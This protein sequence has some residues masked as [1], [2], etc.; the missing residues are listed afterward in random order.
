MR[1]TISTLVAVA[2]AL[3]LIAA[4]PVWEPPRMWLDDTVPEPSGTHD[5]M[6]NLN[7]GSFSVVL[8]Q[9]PL[10]N[11]STR[12]HAVIGRRGD[13]GESLEWVCLE[14]TDAQGKLMLWLESGEIHG[15]AIGGVLV[16]RLSSDQAVD[17]RCGR[18]A[19][20][21]TMP[22]TVRL[23]MTKR[24]VL[25]SLG[26]PTSERDEAVNYSSCHTVKLKVGRTAEPQTFDQCSSLSVRF[27][28]GV[29]CAFEV[30][31]TTTS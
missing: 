1:I 20:P 22:L 19:A 23:G 26:R 2:L 21:I 9:T 3:G 10:Q 12:F 18:L 13:A 5:F 24:A 16:Q 6:P 27:E 7:I 17:E 14:G 31:R 28:K 29:V 30:W 11:A 15:P 8:E 4:S 25:G